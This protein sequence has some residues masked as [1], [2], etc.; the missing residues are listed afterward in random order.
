[1]HVRN[2]ISTFRLASFSVHHICRSEYL[3][4]CFRFNSRDCALAICSISFAG[5]YG[6]LGDYSE[7]DLQRN[8]NRF[9]LIHH[10]DIPQPLLDI[11]HIYGCDIH[12]YNYKR[13]FANKREGPV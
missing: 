9:I 8:D 1:M 4:V 2:I 11:F 5:T 12:S 3:Y 7:L 6:N 13:V 10:T